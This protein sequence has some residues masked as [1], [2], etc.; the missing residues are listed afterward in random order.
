MKNKG[1][2]FAKVT[3]VIS[4]VVILVNGF[5]GF[6]KYSIESD[7]QAMIEIAKSYDEIFADDFTVLLEID[8]ERKTTLSSYSA[9]FDKTSKLLTM[10]IDG[11]IYTADI[12]GESAQA[13]HDQFNDFPGGE[14]I[15][16][17]NFSSESRERIV[18]ELTTAINSLKSSDQYKKVTDGYQL[19][20]GQSIVELKTVGGQNLIT[21]NN[22]VREYTITVT[23]GGSNNGE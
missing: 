23:M 11:E 22:Q 8:G 18:N 6:K 4:L 5:I 15:E 12:E 17:Q 1:K 7:K 13:Y 9:E 19:W 3:I 2:N 10:N 21:I 20:V 14:D 16:F